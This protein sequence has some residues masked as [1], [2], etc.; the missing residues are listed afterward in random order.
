LIDFSTGRGPPHIRGPPP[1]GAYFGR[2]GAF[3]PPTAGCE[4][5]GLG[6]PDEG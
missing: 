2:S 5:L 6:N 4:P 1:V 3:G